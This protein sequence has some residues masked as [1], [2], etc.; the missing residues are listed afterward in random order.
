MEVPSSYSYSRLVILK[1][2]ENSGSG[3]RKQKLDS[4]Q[5][6]TFRFSLKLRPKAAAHTG[7]GISVFREQKTDN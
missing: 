7:C 1:P 6:F 3:N 5:L 2:I 4:F